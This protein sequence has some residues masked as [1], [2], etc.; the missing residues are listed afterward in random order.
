MLYRIALNRK[1]REFDPALHALRDLLAEADMKGSD[2]V[3]ARLIEVED[4]LATLDHIITRFLESETGSRTMLNFVKT[5]A[6]K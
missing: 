4:I 3:H 6:P 5:M 1:A 2:K